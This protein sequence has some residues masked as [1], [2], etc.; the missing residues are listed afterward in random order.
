M[1]RLLITIFVLTIALMSSCSNDRPVQD[2][3]YQEPSY[4]TQTSQPQ[5]IIVKD[6]DGSDFVMDMLLYNALMS[7]GGRGNVVNY[8]YGHPGD[9][10]IRYNSGYRHNPRI[11]SNFRGITYKRS[12][13][14][15]YRSSQ[16]TNTYTPSRSSSSYTPSRSSYRPSRS[17]SSYSRSSSSYSPS[18]SSSS[19]R[20]SS[21]SSRSSSRSSSSSSRRR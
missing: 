8:Y 10:R 11:R 16:R 5:T 17:S 18:R 13:P 19:R 1:K 9:S 12:T 2:Y 21:S 15:Y 20:S 7:Q 14:N 3:G 4:Q 6:N